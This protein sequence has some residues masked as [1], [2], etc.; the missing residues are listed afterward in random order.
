MGMLLPAGNDHMGPLPGK[1]LGDG[2]ADAGAAADE[3]RYFFMQFSMM[4]FT[5]SVFDGSIA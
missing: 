4:E 3:D 2:P 1:P 5:L